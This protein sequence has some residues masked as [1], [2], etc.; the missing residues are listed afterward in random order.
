MRYHKGQLKYLTLDSIS[1][2]KSE[3][4]R[5][6]EQHE[7]YR[8]N[9]HHTPRGEAEQQNREFRMGQI[10]EQLLVFLSTKH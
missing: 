4:K 9:D 8:E 1:Q 5:L 3:I 10:Q 6:R 7:L 2:L